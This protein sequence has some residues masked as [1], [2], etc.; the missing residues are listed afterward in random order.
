MTDL[1]LRDLQTL[2][3]LQS[4]LGRFAVGTQESLHA[5]EAEIHRTQEW[6]QE[7]VSHWQRQVEQ[8]RREVA[9]AE[10]DLRRCEA[11]G[12]RD[13]DGH[14]Y[15]PDCRAEMRALA[16][17]QAHL[18]ECE[19]HLRTA[20]AWRSRV[21]QAVNEYWREARRLSKLAGGHTENAR[22]FL[23][24]AEG[25]YRE[26]LSAASS[27]GAVGTVVAGMLG[28]APSPAPSSVPGIT[29]AEHRAILKRMEA[30]EPL[31]LD[32][33]AKLK[34]PIS[35][36]QTGTLQEDTRWIQGLI[37]SES[38]LEAMRD[39]REAQDLR[40]AILATLKAINYWRSKS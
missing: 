10:A 16:R 4:A 1:N 17:A 24:R 14:Y 35:D 31:A 15:P 40:D 37:D 22:S 12:Y 29:W 21:E 23:K 2:T 8:A 28:L 7:R 9:R 13:R 19:D 30:G 6:L 34:L 18:R 20:Q 3:D 36:L 38:Y 5:A 33:L 27:V 25:K 26:V 39:S 32:D 11:S